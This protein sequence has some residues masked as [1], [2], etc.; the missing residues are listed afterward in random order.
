MSNSKAKWFLAA[1]LVCCLTP[2]MFADGRKGCDPRDRGCR[3]QQV[4][5]GGS[6]TVYLLGAGVVCASAM[7]LNSRAAKPTQS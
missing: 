2:A 4:P 3:Q 1:F 7:F 6:T 5:E